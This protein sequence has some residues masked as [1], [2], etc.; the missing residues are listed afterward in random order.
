MQVSGRTI[1]Q[2]LPY[3]E[4]AVHTARFG[5]SALGGAKRASSTWTAWAVCGPMPWMRSIR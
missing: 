5:A 1:R 3:S 2:K 4:Q